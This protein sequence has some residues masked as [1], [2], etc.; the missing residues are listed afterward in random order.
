[1][2]M[3]PSTWMKRKSKRLILT[4]GQLN[5]SEGEIIVGKARELI[6][7]IRTYELHSEFRMVEEFLH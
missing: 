1:M 4:V 5:I 3:F 7:S 6:K 2:D